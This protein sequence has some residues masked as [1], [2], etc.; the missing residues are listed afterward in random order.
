MEDKSLWNLTDL[1]ACTILGRYS[2]GIQNERAVLFAPMNLIL[3]LTTVVAFLVPQ[4][5]LRSLDTLST[6]SWC[7]SDDDIFV[8]S[9]VT[10]Q[11]DPPRRGEKFKVFVQGEL[12]ETVDQGSYAHVKVK[13]GFI[14]LIDQSYDV[15]EQLTQVGKQCPLEKGELVI[16]HEVD[17]PREIPPVQCSSSRV[18]IAFMWMPISKMK[19]PLHVWMRT[20]ACRMN[21][22][23]LFVNSFIFNHC[24]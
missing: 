7:S 23:N 11:P 16:E 1:E 2:L 9:K 3:L 13:L 19:L 24:N 21:L 4:H 10:L 20:F 8:P 5:P 6:V 12:K 15:C 22:T 18:D 14:Q 17:I